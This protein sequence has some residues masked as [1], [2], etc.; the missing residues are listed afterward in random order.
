MHNVDNDYDGLARGKSDSLIPCYRSDWPGLLI[1]AHTLLETAN[2]FIAT[3]IYLTRPVSL[4][5]QLTLPDPPF[6]SFTTPMLSYVVRA[7]GWQRV[8]TF[9]THHSRRGE[10]GREWE[11]THPHTVS[12]TSCCLHRLPPFCGRPPRHIQVD[13]AARQQL[14]NIYN[15]KCQQVF[16]F[17]AQHS[18]VLLLVE[19]GQLKDLKP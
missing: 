10:G 14:Q 1:S 3:S 4:H 5:A 15:E 16:I 13:L 17:M 12:A 2:A 8:K 6:G 11:M 7:T 18:S 9:F 19:A